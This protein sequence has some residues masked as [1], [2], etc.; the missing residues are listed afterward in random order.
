M[1]TT[2]QFT[3]EAHPWSESHMMR[4]AEQLTEEQRQLTELRPKIRF[5]ESP[6][7]LDPSMLHIRGEYQ[8]YYCNVIIPFKVLTECAN[9]EDLKEKERSRICRHIHWQ[10][11]TRS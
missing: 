1:N 3:D 7:L 6:Y 8:A 5:K 11:S 4:C 2:Y 10:M 9:P